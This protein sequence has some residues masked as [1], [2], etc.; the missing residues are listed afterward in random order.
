MNDDLTS[1]AKLRD[2]AIELTSEGRPLTARSVAER[3][4]VSTGLIRHYYGSMD[5]L[6]QACDQHIAD[7]IRESKEDAL[8][9][10]GMINVF[11]AV[12]ATGDA[13]VMAYLAR[14]LTE[15]S[16][17][18]NDLVDLLAT[19]AAAYI[20][21][22]IDAD[23]MAPLSDVKTAAQMLTIY[24]LGSLALHDHL[25]RLMDI[26]VTSSDLRSQPGI[27]RYLTVQFEIFRALMPDE[28]ITQL[29]Q[30]IQQEQ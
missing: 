9:N 13:H 10:S 3:A 2:A 28:Y 19:D 18:I 6:T 7:V 14:R 22:A 4:G 16:E 27:K 24:S 15:D 23:F 1:K 5:G 21:Q 8:A 30:Q 25:E 20:Q 11:G 17:Q 26:D 29:T 12:A